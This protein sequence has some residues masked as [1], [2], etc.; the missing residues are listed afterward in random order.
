MMTHNDVNNFGFFV[1]NRRKSIIDGNRH[2]YLID[3]V[4]IQ[5]DSIIYG[6]AKSSPLA[7]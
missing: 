4:L 2:T 6:F 7:F 5:R 1:F 3:Y